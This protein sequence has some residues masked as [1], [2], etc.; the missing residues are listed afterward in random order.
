[1]DSGFIDLDV[2]LSRV[3]HPQS[4][5]YFL[6]AVKAYKAGALRASLTSAWVALVY[7]LIIKCRELSALGDAAATTFIHSWDL[8]TATHDVK[9]LLQLEA[10]I[11]SEAAS[12]IQIINRISHAHLER[13]RQDR[14][15]CAHPAF[16]AEAELFEPSPELVRLHLANVVNMVL[17]QE[18]LQGKAIFDLYDVDIQSAGFPVAH[19]SILNYVEQR[20]LARV[21]PQNIRNFGVV[22]AKSLLKGEPAHWEPHQ[23]KI[24]SSL[25]AVMERNAQAWQ[26][27]SLTIVRLIDTI[28]PEKRPRVIAFLSAFPDFWQLLQE[29]TRTALQET[30]NNTNPATL[31][32]YRILAGLKLPLFREP[33]LNVIEQFTQAQLCN[34]IAMSPFPDLWPHAV[35]FYKE[36]WS[37]RGSESNFRELIAPF[38]GHLT[39]EQHDQLLEA[40]IANGQNWDAAGTDALLLSVLRNAPPANRPTRE[41]RDRFYEHIHTRNRLKK[42]EEIFEMF[43][44]D[45]WVFPPPPIDEDGEEPQP[46]F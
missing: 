39:A 19:A 4:K 37:F 36:S 7:D 26:D 23:D 25:V 14:H 24:V 11:L 2:L 32:E 13:L 3:R 40:V 17:S 35:N 31:T 6:D 27:V 42:Y 46:D 33:L 16:S 5:G 18:P 29:P 41:A 30:V 21:R 20:Y 22:L 1:M 12:N 10:K 44:A 9:R 8:A 43:Q 34:A 15:M 28:E 38:A 45:G